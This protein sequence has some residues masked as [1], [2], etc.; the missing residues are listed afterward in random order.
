MPKVMALLGSGIQNV[1]GCEIYRVTMPLTHLA[2]GD[3]S[4]QVEW[5]PVDE[6]VRSLSRNLR[7]GLARLAKQAD[8]Y[9][10]PR[11]FIP[12]P[13]SMTAFELL[14]GEIHRNGGKI[15]YETDDDYT[16]EHRI[17][18]GGGDSAMHIAGLCDL[19]TVSTPHLRKVMQERVDVPVVDIPNQVACDTWAE[20][21]GKG[22][23]IPELTLG[24]TGSPTHHADWIVLKDVLPRILADYPNVHLVLGGYFPDYF[25]NLQGDQVHRQPPVHYGAYVNLIN[26][27]DIVLAPLEPNDAFN[28]SKSAI[29]VIEGMA[30]ARPV[31]KRVGGAACIAS[32]MPV[33]RRAINNR[34]N[35]LLVA[36]TPEAWEQGLR[37]LIEDNN[38]RARLQLEGLKWVRKHRDI[39]QNWTLWRAAYQELTDRKSRHSRLRQAA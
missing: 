34:N 11:Y 14:V 6:V 25:E 30:A 7:V 3:K 37:T 23:V 29:K 20:P 10:L 4:W 19:V 5:A 26:V 32:D 16:N 8:I 2:D 18:H 13:A 12:S 28:L 15:V 22:R 35:G 38:L 1:G 39:A 33:Y 17:V 36:H 31:G 9:I 27:L 24:L 21:M